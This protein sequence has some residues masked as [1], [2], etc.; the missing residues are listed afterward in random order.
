M[1]HD[2]LRYARANI[3]LFSEVDSGI[4]SCEWSL[5]KPERGIYAALAGTLGLPPEE[6]VF[7]DDLEANIDGARAVGILGILWQDAATARNELKE[8]GIAL[9][10]SLQGN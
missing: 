6:I 3:P 4:F 2:F 5:I 9:P 7:F 1:P 8:R 10:L